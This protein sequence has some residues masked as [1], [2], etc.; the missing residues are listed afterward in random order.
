[1]RPL[2]L[3]FQRFSVS[4]FSFSLFVCGK[5]GETK[6]VILATAQQLLNS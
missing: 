6:E 1:M 3:T 4:V 2:H 5:N